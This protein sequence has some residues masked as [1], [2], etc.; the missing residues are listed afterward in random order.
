VEEYESPIYAGTSRGAKIAALA[1]VLLF[2]IWLVA[3]WP[4]G[5]DAQPGDDAPAGELEDGTLPPE[6]GADVLPGTG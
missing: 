1:L 2:G 3:V 6:V 5:A 4:R